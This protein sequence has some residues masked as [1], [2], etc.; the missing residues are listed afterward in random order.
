MQITK[1]V[2]PA[3]TKPHHC[4][5]NT[6]CL[7]AD[8][9]AC[10]T[11]H[12]KIKPLQ[13]IAHLQMQGLAAAA[14]A[15]MDAIPIP[16][17]IDDQL[18]EVQSLAGATELDIQQQSGAYDLGML[19]L[20]FLDFFGSRFDHESQVVSVRQGGVVL[21]GYSQPLGAVAP[22][23]HL[24]IESPL[25]R[26]LR[27]LL[28]ILF[29]FWAITSLFLFFCRPCPVRHVVCCRAALLQRCRHA[30]WPEEYKAHSGAAVC[31]W[32]AHGGALLL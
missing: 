26:H 5:T 32:H 19:L 31:S 6:L 25:V 17:S 1:H 3:P 14:I 30:T 11:S 24:R 23:V 13:V 2:Q 27:S 29:C 9:E 12:R 18:E 22:G 10:A 28:F 21:D 8:N 4:S 16:S 7:H 20:S 15:P